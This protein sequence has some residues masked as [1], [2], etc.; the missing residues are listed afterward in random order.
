MSECIR[1]AANAYILSVVARLKSLPNHEVLFGASGMSDVPACEGGPC[2]GGGAAWCARY[3]AESWLA[4][5]L[6]AMVGR[7][8]QEHLASNYKTAW[9]TVGYPWL[10]GIEGVRVDAAVANTGCKHVASLLTFVRAT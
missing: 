10:S 2:G 9:S 7:R 5:W 8:L 6:T 1:F 3:P 4:G